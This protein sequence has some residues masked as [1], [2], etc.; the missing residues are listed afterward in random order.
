MINSAFCVAAVVIAANLTTGSVASPLSISQLSNRMLNMV[1]TGSDELVAELISKGVASQGKALQEACIQLGLLVIGAVGREMDVSSLTVG[2]A[3]G[4]DVAS[5]FFQS[6]FKLL[7]QSPSEEIKVT[8]ALCIGHLSVGNSASCFQKLITAITGDVV[9]VCLFLLSIVDINL[10][11]S[12]DRSCLCLLATL[13][14]SIACARN[15]CCYLH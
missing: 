12:V 14:H 2:G 6:A 13:L 11:I 9:S 10:Q 8:A 15:I 4:V 1:T 3:S 5:L 7:D